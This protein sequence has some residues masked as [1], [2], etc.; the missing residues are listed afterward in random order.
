MKLSVMKNKTASYV[1]S[2][3][4][5]I[6]SLFFMFKNGFEWG[7]E[8]RGGTSVQLIFAE[9]A[10]EGKIRNAF[11]KVAA[12]IE[13]KTGHQHAHLASGKIVIQPVEGEHKQ[14]E[15][16]VK[17]PLPVIL[18]AVN[19][20]EVLNELNKE[21]PHEVVSTSNIGAA[22]GD[23]MKSDGLVA[24]AFSIIGMLVY[25]AWRFNF[26][27]AVGV[28]AAVTQDFIIMLGFISF[29]KMTFDTTILAAL[30][31]LLGYSVNNSIVIFD[32]IRENR[33]L[34]KAGTPPEEL[35]DLS[36]NQSLI[37]AFNTT[38]TTLLALM[39]LTLFGGDSIHGFAVSLVFGNLVG[40]LSSIFLASPIA[41]ETMKIRG[42]KKKAA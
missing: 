21:L 10:D 26:D 22:V 1:V 35:I 20:D 3:T 37:R 25:L 11:D 23:K 19:D 40:T 32:R 33:R 31:T 12:A 38:F 24:A 18:E 29:T 8:F 7:I 27:D 41:Y 17:Y 15:F 16:I 9:Q 42:A 30:L 14:Q 2:I 39:A 4:L 34:M 13:Q 5:V 6:L 28:I 36:V